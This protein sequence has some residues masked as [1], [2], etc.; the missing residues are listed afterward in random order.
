MLNFFSHNSK[1]FA[2]VKNPYAQFI[3]LRVASGAQTYLFPYRRNTFFP[4]DFRTAVLTKDGENFNGR[5][6]NVFVDKN[7]LI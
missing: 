5:S 2:D 4:H 1:L 6:V 3:R 7:N